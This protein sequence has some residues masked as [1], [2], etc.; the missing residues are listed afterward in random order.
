MKSLH[1]K[2]TSTLVLVS[3]VLLG[4]SFGVAAAEEV[5]QSSLVVDYLAQKTI[6]SYVPEHAT[7]VEEVQSGSYQLTRRDE[8][9]MSVWTL[10]RPVTL[11]AD[12][13][14]RT[15]AQIEL[16]EA[17]FFEY[18]DHL[19]RYEHGTFFQTTGETTA[20]PAFIPP[21]EFSDGVVSRK[22]ASDGVGLAIWADM[23]TDLLAREF[24]RV[25]TSEEP[26]VVEWRAPQGETAFGT[27]EYVRRHSFLPESGPLTKVEVFYRYS[28]PQEVEVPLMTYEA[29]RWDRQIPGHIRMVQYSSRPMDPSSPQDLAGLLAETQ[30]E[31]NIQQSFELVLRF[32][33]EANE[34]DT[35]TVGDVAEL[36][37]FVKLTP[38]SAELP[39]WAATNDP[40]GE[41]VRLLSYDAESKVWL[42]TANP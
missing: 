9:V 22:R 25:V 15:E 28:A 2:P 11:A 27:A 32:Q 40:T 33:R 36:I 35:V 20:G 6:R 8:A 24:T 19:G 14:G 12:P 26:L 41:P 13:M 30:A 21:L 18:G 16:I 42:P 29:N 10:K 1:S 4:M 5:A 39:V 31:V 17:E 3:A 34:G 7:I 37:H 23:E 38:S